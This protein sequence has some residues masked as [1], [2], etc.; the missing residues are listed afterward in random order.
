MFWI[1]KRQINYHIVS[2][3]EKKNKMSKSKKNIKRIIQND[4]DCIIIISA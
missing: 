1:F 2:T 3:N 4:D